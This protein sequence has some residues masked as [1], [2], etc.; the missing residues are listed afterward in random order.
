MRLQMKWAKSFLTTK[1]V[2]EHGPDLRREVWTAEQA[3]QQPSFA[4]H[5]RPGAAVPT[6]VVALGTVFAE[7]WELEAN[8]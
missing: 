3:K 8:G 5:G 6:W 4:R 2:R 1:D 7:D